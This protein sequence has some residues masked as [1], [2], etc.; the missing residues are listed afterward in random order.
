MTSI[1]LEPKQINPAINLAEDINVNSEA[2]QAP[3]L[4][5]E[6]DLAGLHNAPINNPEIKTEAKSNQP[7]SLR[8]IVKNTLPPW[9][10]GI[11]SLMHLTT[12]GILMLGGFSKKTQDTITANVTGFT[13]LI[14][15]LVYTDLAYEAFKKG[16]AFDFL[17]RIAE[18]IMNIFVD[19]NHYHLFRAFSSA[20]NQ[21]HSIN[22]PRVTKDAPIWKNFLENLEASKEF[23]QEIWMGKGGGLTK[24][25]GGGENDKGHTL[26]FASH[27][28]IIVGVLALLNGFK[29][30]FMNRAL[31]IG[32]NVAGVIADLG[33]LF[34]KDFSAKRVG[35][36][37]ILHAIGDT[38]KRFVPDKW[39][40]II[41]NAIMPFYNA[42]LYYFGLMG[43]R[44]ADGVYLSHEAPH[45]VNVA[46]QTS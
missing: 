4:S 8:T 42:G 38:I 20:L 30:N 28:Q 3:Q 35:I 46:V 18:P 37:Y 31:G 32:R 44:Q 34:E 6:P 15:S 23:F 12:S 25:L 17:G 13:K 22:L 16:F 24:V 7:K 19:L 11:S 5:P 40:D 41:D 1:A 21:L 36:F 27:L 29:R 10:Y 2:K 39:Q 33:M 14:N 43:R 9:A 26:A 45:K